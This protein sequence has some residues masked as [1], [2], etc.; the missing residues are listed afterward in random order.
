MYNVQHTLYNT[1]YNTL[2][3]IDTRGVVLIYE[4]QQS[5]GKLYT[6]HVVSASQRQ[7]RECSSRGGVARRTA[8]EELRKNWATP[9]E[10]MMFFV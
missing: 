5:R 10:T 7:G 9:I 1:T 3:L 6:M 2:K 4:K 8:R